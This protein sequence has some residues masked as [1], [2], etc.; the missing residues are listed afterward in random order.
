MWRP[1]NSTSYSDLA[2]SIYKSFITL[3]YYAPL[4]V[5]YST[6]YWLTFPN[7]QIMF[8]AETFDQNKPF[9]LSDGGIVLLKLTEHIFNFKLRDVCLVLIQE[10]DT[11]RTALAGSFIIFWG[12]ITE[13]NVLAF[14]QQLSEHRS[15]LYA[16]T[17]LK[18]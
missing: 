1:F 7:Y 11:Y 13:V 5:N 4:L 18:N 8:V 15:C 16:F 14:F 17:A 10:P 12:N 3:I 6:F 2:V 9:L